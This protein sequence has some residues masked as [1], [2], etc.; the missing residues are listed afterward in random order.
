MRIYK[1]IK[2][3]HSNYV[4]LDLKNNDYCLITLF[5]YN[6][7]N[8]FYCK[9]LF[10]QFDIKKDIYLDIIKDDNDFLDFFIGV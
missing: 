7:Y 2:E 8:D 4:K 1:D 6:K 3:I 10:G 9:N 5:R